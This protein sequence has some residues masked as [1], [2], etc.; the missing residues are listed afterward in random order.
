MDASIVDC[1]RRDAGGMGIPDGIASAG[2]SAPR[3][4]IPNGIASA[5]RCAPAVGVPQGGRLRR[6]FPMR[7][8]QR[9]G[10]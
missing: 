8:V 5:G 9:A 10:D 4:S 6:R 2:P 1:V 3:R 7:A